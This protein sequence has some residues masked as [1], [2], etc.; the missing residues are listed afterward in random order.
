MPRHESLPENNSLHPWRSATRPGGWGLEIRG[1]HLPISVAK[2][3]LTQ[4]H[5]LNGFG[6]QQIWDVAEERARGNLQ[7]G[8]TSHVQGLSIF[9]PTNVV[10]CKSGAVF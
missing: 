4:K 9:S 3:G 5:D 10:F 6:N 2:L 7:K 1:L 8:P